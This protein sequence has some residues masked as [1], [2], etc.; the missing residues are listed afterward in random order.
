MLRKYNGGDFCGN[1]FENLCKKCGIARNKTTPYKPQHNGVVERMN[2]RYMEKERSMLR[3]DG[4][5][6]E[7]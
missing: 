5:G 2:R 1:E 3:S 7:F 6:Q 4:I